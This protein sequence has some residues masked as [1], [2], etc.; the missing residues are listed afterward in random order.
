MGRKLIYLASPYSHKLT[1]IRELRF[2]QVCRAA[3]FL[4]KEGNM[5]YSPIA[6]SHNISKQGLPANYEFWQEF[7]T[8]MIALCDEIWV[9][10]LKDW[11]KSIGIKEELAY[12]NTLGKPVQFVEYRKEWV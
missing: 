11:E 3:M 12:A 5:I 4:I 7:D 1:A 10:M 9:L 2:R 6:H 8:R